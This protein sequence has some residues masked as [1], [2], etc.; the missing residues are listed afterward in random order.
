VILQG[1]NLYRFVGKMALFSESV[2]GGGETYYHFLF[3]LFIQERR[4]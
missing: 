2:Q 4:N 1:V 3:F